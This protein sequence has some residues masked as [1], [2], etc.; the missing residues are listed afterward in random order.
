MSAF[1]LKPACKDY[2]WE[3][4]CVFIS[5]SSGSFEVNGDCEMLFVRV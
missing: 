4:S 2:L 1:L 3:G 5:A